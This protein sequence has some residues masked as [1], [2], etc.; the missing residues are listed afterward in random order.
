M[1]ASTGTAASASHCCKTW[2]KQLSPALYHPLILVHWTWWSLRTCN[3]LPVQESHEQRGDGSPISS[4]PHLEF[5]CLHLLEFRVQILPM[6]ELDEAARRRL[7]KQLYIPL[8]CAA[9]RRLMLDRALGAYPF[10]AA[11]ALS[12][13][14]D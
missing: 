5:F 12:I 13:R 7:P 10:L 11:V 3:I 2:P 4:T 14:H 1:S 6:Q 9:A 8:P